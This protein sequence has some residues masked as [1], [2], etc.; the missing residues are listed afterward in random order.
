MDA[1]YGR[2]TDLRDEISK[3]GLQYVAA[4]REDMTILL[5][6]P[7]STRTRVAVGDLAK[8][9]PKDQW[10]SV[11]WRHGTKGDMRSRFALVR[12]RVAHPESG[13]R[14]ERPL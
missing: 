12:V 13:H 4:V 8:A 3:R 7:K 1:G 11:W 2:A 5:P 6:G 10:R 9:L 14:R